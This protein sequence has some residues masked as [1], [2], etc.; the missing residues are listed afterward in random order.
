[1]T[2]TKHGRLIDHGLPVACPWTVVVSGTPAFSTTK[3]DRHDIAEIFL[4]VALNTKI[5]KNQS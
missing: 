5:K 3:P 1:M 2:N 4:K